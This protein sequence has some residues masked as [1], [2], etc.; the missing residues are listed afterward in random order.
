MAPEERS[1]LESLDLRPLPV[2]LAHRFSRLRFDN[3][4]ILTLM[5]LYAS[6][7]THERSICQAEFLRQLQWRLSGRPFRFQM[8]AN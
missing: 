2:A 3:P 5:R 1:I 6:L 8:D 4:L 7:S